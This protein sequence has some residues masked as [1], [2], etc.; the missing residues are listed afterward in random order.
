MRE[1]QFIEQNKAKWREFE[2]LVA[3]KDSDPEKLG[4]LF[5]QITDDLSYARTFYP[6]R[7][8]RVY[9]NKL[10]QNVF[11]KLYKS[12][13]RKKN[14]LL[15]FFAD[16]IPSAVFH[17]RKELLISSLIFVISIC[18]GIFSAIQD[19]DFTKSILSDEYIEMTEENIA[20]NDP[21]AVYKGDNQFSMFTMIAAN[22]LRIDFM[23][24]ISGLAFGL[25]T[26][27]M[28]VY[29]SLIHI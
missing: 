10:A 21:M 20:K 27:L 13:K 25:W 4:K 1:R 5:I 15:S 24:F 3:N 22:N 6:N 14:R 11:D 12:R 16:D 8:V 28:L 29:L 17:A 9:L 26:I 2:M 23:T 7:S 18:I 19:P